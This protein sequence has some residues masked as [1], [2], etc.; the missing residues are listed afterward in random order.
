MTR[1][2][3][4][5]LGIVAA[6]VALRLAR[7]DE[8]AIDVLVRFALLSLSSA[9]AEDTII[10]AYGYYGYATTWSVFVDRVPLVVVVVWP[11]V[12]D[13]AAVL[14]RALGGDR[15]PTPLR[16]AALT[17]VIVLGDA[18][19]IEPVAVR[20]GLWRWTEPGI[21]AV[22][23]IG[24]LGW[25][26]FAFFATWILETRARPAVLVVAP[27]ASHVVL[28]GAWWAGLR[29]L[30]RPLPSLGVVL[31]VVLVS[32]LLV[33]RTTFDPRAR[34]VPMRALLMRAPGASFFFVLLASDFAAPASFAAPW[35]A[36]W[37][38]PPPGGGLLAAYVAAFAAP[39]LAATARSARTARTARAGGEGAVDEGASEGRA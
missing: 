33:A 32:L 31:V 39:Y 38:P 23:V 2:E 20:A 22:P 8:R 26:V 13:S 6:Y 18:A 7:R 11:V 25:A 5:C 4:L 3:I 37:S 10:H 1:L 29:Y 19:L 21:F 16:L 35:A 14:A 17:S 28:V 36:A 15:A 24:I 9:V 34:G 30:E 12:V 27:A